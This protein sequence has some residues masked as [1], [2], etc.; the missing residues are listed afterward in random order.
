MENVEYIKKV[1]CVNCGECGHVIKNC[2]GPI[3]SFGI[4][5]FKIVENKEQEIND[6]PDI[7]KPHIYPYYV[8]PARRVYHKIKFLMIQRKD[9][10]S[11]IDFLRGKYPDTEPEKTNMLK[12][13]FS[14]MTNVER[15]SL[16]E[17][18]FDQLW[19]N[20]WINKSS[21]LYKNEKV[22]SKEK[23]SNINI[24]SLLDSTSSH[25]TL[26]EFGFPKGRRNIKESNI[27][28]AE[29]EFFE[30]TGYEKHMYDFIKNYPIIEEEFIA[31]NNVTY[32]HKYYLVKLKDEF[33]NYIPPLSQTQECEVRSIG[34][35]TIEE[36]TSLIRDYDCQK[37]IIIKNVYDNI[38]KMNYKYELSEYYYHKKINY[39]KY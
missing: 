24:D 14:E 9:T 1:H 2:K 12:V 20:L 37:K 7:I 21:R 23:F 36:C 19:E 17:L 10:M 6:I 29:R 35:Y 13:Q 22:S 33:K 39:P 8:C 11:Y 26:Q 32:K 25:W 38:I 31:T 15:Q 16:K 5:I 4:I 27:A 28:C 34:W 30:E 18:T 3:T